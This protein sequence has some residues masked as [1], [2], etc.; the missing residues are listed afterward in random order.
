EKGLQGSSFF[1]DHIPPVFEK[2]DGMFNFD[3]VG[4]GDGTG[5]SMSPEP[6]L[7]QKVFE[8]ADESVNVL[9]NVRFLRGVGVRGSDYAPF[10]QKGIPSVSFASNVPHI[11]YHQTGDTIY[12]I[13]PDIMADIA[14][15]AFIAG[16]MWADR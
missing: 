6:E 4:E 16:Y 15:L 5:C 12:R 11:G 13:N 2:A 10:Y 3:M 9:R 1:A 8:K 14:K 7:L